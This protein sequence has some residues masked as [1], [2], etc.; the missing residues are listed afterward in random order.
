[1]VKELVWKDVLALRGCRNGPGKFLLSFCH[2]SQI[3]KSR[4]P[5]LQVDFDGVP[6]DY[7]RAF[8]RSS[9]KLMFVCSSQQPLD[10][11]CIGVACFVTPAPRSHLLGLVAQRT[12]YNVQRRQLPSEILRLQRGVSKSR[13]L[14]LLELNSSWLHTA[15]LSIIV[16]RYS[17]SV[18]IHS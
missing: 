12:T 7:S 13:C 5:K 2:C 8:T 16:V 11:F 4:E 10:G 9:F 18:L 15:S 14:S 3:F 6:D 1:V 17:G